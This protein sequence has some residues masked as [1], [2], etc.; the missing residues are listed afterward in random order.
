MQARLM[1]R[2]NLFLCN[3]SPV[4]MGFLYQFVVFIALQGVRRGFVHH[5]V[6]VRCLIGPKNDENYEF[7]LEIP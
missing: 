3:V 6:M 2:P 7:K 5:F 4:S 1:Q